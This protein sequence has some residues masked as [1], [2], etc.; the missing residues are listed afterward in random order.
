MVS[1]DLGTSLAPQFARVGIGA[2]AAAVTPL[3]VVGAANGVGVG[4]ILAT[5]NCPTSNPYFIVGTS[6]TGD[7]LTVQFYRGL[8]LGIF[9]VSGGVG[10]FTLDIN[11]NMVCQA[12]NIT[13]TLGI[14]TCQ[15]SNGVSG[16]FN[17][18]NTCTVVGGIITSIA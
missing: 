11:G 6:S 3:T 2:A 10:G 12:G 8:N 9:A 4:V 5:F 17:A 7:G 15:G 16:T 14:Y 18:T 1:A 13:A